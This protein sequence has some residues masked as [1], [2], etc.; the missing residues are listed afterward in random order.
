MC[1]RNGQETSDSFLVSCF[2]S[3]GPIMLGALYNSISNVHAAALLL[4][5]A[6]LLSRLLGV[7]RDRMLAAEFG[8]GR[9]LDIYYA[10]FQIP[11]FLSVIFLL[12]A[13]SS[14]IIPVF[15]EYAARDRESAARL[16]A[17]ASM[18]F[19][20][21]AAAAAV[22][23]FF[24]APAIVPLIAPGFSS[25]ELDSLAI[26][27]RIILISPILLGLSGIWGSVN[28]A[29][30]RFLAFALA[31][32]LYNIGIIAGIVFFVPEAGIF[33]LG[34]GVV[35]GALLHCGIEYAVA[36][37]LGFSPFRH[38]SIS[39]FK[40][41]LRDGVRRIAALALPR[42]LSVS[43]SQLTLLLL[44]AFAS[45]FVEGSIAVFTFAQNLYSLPIGIFGVSYA[46]AIFPRMSEAYIRRDAARFFE[47]LYFGIRTILFWMAPFTALFIVLRAHIVRVALGA[48]AFS[49][50]DTRLVAAA[51]AALAAAFVAGGLVTF[52]IR[53]FYALE[54]TWLP[55]AVNTIA[56]AATVGAALWIARLFDAATPVGA[57]LS[58]LFRIGDL[59]HR[60]VVGLALGFSVILI[61]NVVCL[62]ILLRRLASRRFGF[63][64]PFPFRFVLHIAFATAAA[65]AAAYVVRV[66]FSETLPLITFAQVMLQ[67]AVAGLAGFAVYAGVLFSF[68]NEDIGAVFESVRR[69]LWSRQALPQNWK[70]ENKM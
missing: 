26:L 18:I 45:T 68:K 2:V 44:I 53:G 67:G 50:E 69:R 28:Q 22:V 35:L 21:C 54:N 6:G 10:A 70:E 34:A 16:V 39:T 65:A 29:F 49:W 20:G 41:I 48:G 4:G 13:A 32:I 52:L 12:G 8:A 60:G 24:A 57:A 37:R 17:V 43:L 11:D 38:I 14:A 58:A 9:E 7:L 27:T 47:E 55:L 31:P 25:E 30:Q 40:A 51:L 56:S 46:I 62:W 19:F 23:A 1:N 66:S 63:V 5:A 3:H 61:C 64:P 42:V 59:P 15:Q 33:G 36:S